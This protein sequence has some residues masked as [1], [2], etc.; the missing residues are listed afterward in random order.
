MTSAD[1]LTL[2]LPHRPPFVFIDA[3]V[4]L[5]PGESARA[6]K[7]F[8]SAESFFAGH[9]PG[10]PIVPGVILAE[11]LAQIAGI[12]GAS[13]GKQISFLLSAIK[14]MKFRGAVRPGDRIDL[15]A[16]RIAKSGALWQFEVSARVG[17][18]EVAMGTIV[19]S[20]AAE[21]LRQSDAP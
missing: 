21:E 15:S 13:E 4:D 17:D 12:A 18:Q 19:L 8:S 1:P 5:V 2:G 11:A 3:V 7:T 10:N 20:E 14:T 9:F 16:T 6:H